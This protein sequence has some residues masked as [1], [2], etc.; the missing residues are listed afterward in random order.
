MGGH[1]ISDRGHDVSQSV[2]QGKKCV[3]NTEKSTARAEGFPSNDVS[4]TK[5][6]GGAWEVQLAGENRAWPA[7]THDTSSAPT[8]EVVSV[9]CCREPS[10]SSGPG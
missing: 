2:V 4:R 9:R 5:W 8:Q 1:L 3:T 7:N 6:L 10:G